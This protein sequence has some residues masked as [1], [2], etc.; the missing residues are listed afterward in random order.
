[1]DWSSQRWDKHP[2]DGI[3][4]EDTLSGAPC[5]VEAGPGW[6]RKVSLP[7]RFTEPVAFLLDDKRTGS[8][9]LDCKNKH[10]L[11][12]VRSQCFLINNQ[13]KKIASSQ[14]P[15]TAGERNQ[16]W[17]VWSSSFEGYFLVSAKT[18][19]WQVKNNTERDR[20]QIVV[21]ITH[22]TTTGDLIRMK[23]FLSSRELM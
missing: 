11:I 9:C 18:R 20:D 6:Q 2:R 22:P 21:S 8:P 19:L 5:E 23:R 15:G 4:T 12:T 7:A 10:R 1:M 3:H 17:T 16:K 14:C 13:R